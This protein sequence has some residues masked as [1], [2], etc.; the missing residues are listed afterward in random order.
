MNPIEETM[1]KSVKVYF[2]NGN[3][4]FTEINGTKE[5]IE[6]YYVGQVFNVGFG[7]GDNLQTAVRVEFLS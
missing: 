4:L 1:R 6:R 7:E 3:Y 2:S 5:E